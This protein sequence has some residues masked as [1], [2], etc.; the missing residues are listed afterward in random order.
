MFRCL[1]HPV[2]V[3]EM[4]I[5]VVGAGGVGAAAAA[6]AARRD[7]FAQMVLADVDRG[8]GERARAG[9]STTAATTGP[10][11]RASAV[12]SSTAAATVCLHGL[13]HEGQEQRW[14]SFPSSDHSTVS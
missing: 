7:F 3:A 2:S 4:R 13:R 6:I 9:S 14:H 11:D 1:R 10:R 8:R 12:R 5:L